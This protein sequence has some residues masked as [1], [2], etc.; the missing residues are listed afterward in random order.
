MGS[1]LPCKSVGKEGTCAL[2][3][4]SVERDGRSHTRGGIIIYEK[5]KK[6]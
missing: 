3:H 6:N 1:A 2:K 4:V 5:K